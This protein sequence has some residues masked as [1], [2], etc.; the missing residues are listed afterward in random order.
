[1][2]MKKLSLLFSGSKQ[3]GIVE[4]TLKHMAQLS[5]TKKYESASEKLSEDLKALHLMLYGDPDHEA[6]AEDVKKLIPMILEVDKD[7]HNLFYKLCKHLKDLEFEAKKQAS[8]IIC[9]VV[10]KCNKSELPE[11]LQNHSDIF[12]Y[13]MEG[14]EDQQLAQHAG[15]V[16]QEMAKRS[17]IG[18]MLFNVSLSLKKTSSTIVFKPSLQAKSSSQFLDRLCVY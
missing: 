11:Y 8:Q 12:V 16:L 10:R 13:L 18:P 7:G 14:F 6:N 9:F 1:M 4:N 15:S 3:V 2:A 5:D 17:E